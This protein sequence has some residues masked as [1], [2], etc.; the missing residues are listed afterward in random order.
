[1]KRGSLIVPASLSASELVGV[2]QERPMESGTPPAWI[3]G[4]ARGSH[5]IQ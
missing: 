5:N 1:V 4:R 3:G 2:V